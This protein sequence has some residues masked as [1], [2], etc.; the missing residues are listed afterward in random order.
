M[1]G[2][3]LF[4]EVAAEGAGE[5]REE[6]SCVARGDWIADGWVCDGF[7]A[8][9]AAAGAD[10]ADAVVV[11]MGGGGFASGDCGV[12]RVALGFGGADIGE[13]VDVRGAHDRGTRI[14]Y[15]G[16]LSFGAQS[17]LF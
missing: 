3:F 1:G 17:D 8:A 7:L 10:C 6:G 5:S 9:E 13:A 15:A 14:S 16:A 4:Q 11:A 2:D 12:V